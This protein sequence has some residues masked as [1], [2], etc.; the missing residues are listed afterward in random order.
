MKHGVD[1]QEQYW[2]LR[3]RDGSYMYIYDG[4][5]EVFA[6]EEKANAEANRFRLP[7][8]TDDP[9]FTVVKARLVVED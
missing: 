1:L 7:W 3:Y 2:L 4:P 9:E 8:L 5:P 6:S